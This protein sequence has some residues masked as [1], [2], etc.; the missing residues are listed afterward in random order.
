MK[1]QIDNIIPSGYGHFKVS[2]TYSNGKL[3]SA[4]TTD[5][6]AIDVY[7]S[8]TFTRTDERMQ[9]QAEKQLIRIVKRANNLR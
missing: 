3:Y 5:T 2:I 8:D 4:V 1:T 9:R 7:R 6:M